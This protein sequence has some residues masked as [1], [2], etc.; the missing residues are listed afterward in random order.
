MAARQGLGSR[1]QVS[2]I[3]RIVLLLPPATVPLRC[4]GRTWPAIA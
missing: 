4:R 3:G 1:L 2:G